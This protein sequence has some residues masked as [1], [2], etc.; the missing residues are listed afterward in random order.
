MENLLYVA[1]TTTW[2]ISFKNPDT[3]TEYPIVIDYIQ[4]GIN[5]WFFNTTMLPL[6]ILPLPFIIL[7]IKIN[8]LKL[9]V[10]HLIHTAVFFLLPVLIVGEHQLFVNTASDCNN[11]PNIANY[12]TYV[13]NIDGGTAGMT[14]AEATKLAVDQYTSVPQSIEMDLVGLPQTRAFLLIYFIKSCH[15]IFIFVIFG[16]PKKSY[17]GFSAASQNYLKINTYNAVFLLLITTSILSYIVVL[18]L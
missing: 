4:Q 2:F 10:D 17:K 1:I 8:K 6:L 7:I 18:Y 12:S 11:F 9:K 13:S 3:T 16:N 5:I 14:I 15:A